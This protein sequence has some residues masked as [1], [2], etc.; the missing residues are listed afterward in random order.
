MSN[1]DPRPMPPAV[2]AAY[3]NPTDLYRLLWSNAYS[4]QDRKQVRDALL[5]ALVRDM[6]AVHFQHGAKQTRTIVQKLKTLKRD[7]IEFILSIEDYGGRE[8]TL[9]YLARAMEPRWRA[10]WDSM[11]WRSREDVIS[12]GYAMDSILGNRQFAWISAQYARRALRFNT[13][14]NMA[15]AIE[16]IEATEEWAER[17]SDESKR[18][19][20]KAFSL[21]RAT[22][23]NND[24][25]MTD[26]GYAI[27][28]AESALSICAQV[29]TYVPPQACAYSVI[30]SF[31]ANYNG[32]D[33]LMSGSRLSDLAK[34]L[35][36]PSLL[37]AR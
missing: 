24:L 20:A 28:A 19:A 4:Q 22:V 21:S 37:D 10:Y 36:T 13:T 35:I 34:Q 16:A 33:S 32:D 1:S 2:K 29:L 3:R 23:S 18:R 27:A 31:L 26:A 9:P 11:I 6:G 30:R 17:P 8:R 7:H 5:D 14:A 12:W 25:I 15:L